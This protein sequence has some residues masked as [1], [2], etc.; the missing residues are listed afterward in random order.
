VCGKLIQCKV[1]LGSS[2]AANS[3]VY[4]QELTSRNPTDLGSIAMLQGGPHKMTLH[5][6]AHAHAHVCSIELHQTGRDQTRNIHGQR[7]FT[8]VTHHWHHEASCFGD[9]RNSASSYGMSASLPHNWAA[10]ACMQVFKVV[11]RLLK[12][13]ETLDISRDRSIIHNIR[14]SC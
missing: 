4:A 12:V 1:F 8:V 6:H 2:R 10:A 13:T 5:A 3:T 11:L 9:P 7:S 14:Y